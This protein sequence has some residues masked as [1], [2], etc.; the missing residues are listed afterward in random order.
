MQVMPETARKPG[1]GI[2]PWD[3]KTQADLAACGTCST[4][5]AFSTSKY[6]GDTGEGSSR[7]QR[8]FR[9]RVDKAGCRS[10]ESWKSARLG[11]LQH[12]CLKKLFNMLMKGIKKLG[13]SVDHTAD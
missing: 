13:M 4:A 3:G 12:P 2:R 5:A 10:D 11:R 9:E 8:R 6:E 7:L 1:F